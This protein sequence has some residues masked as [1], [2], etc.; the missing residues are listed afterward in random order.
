MYDLLYIKFAL[1]Y[2]FALGIIQVS[3]LYWLMTLKHAEF[4]KHP[5][6]RCY[7]CAFVL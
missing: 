2:I 5:I 3:M 4:F 1:T 6:M 7:G